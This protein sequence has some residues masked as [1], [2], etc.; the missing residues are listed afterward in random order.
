MADE[1]KPQESP[2]YEFDAPKFFDFTRLLAASENKNSQHTN[3][4]VDAFYGFSSPPQSAT[5]RQETIDQTD[6]KSVDCNGEDI[7]DED[8][9]W[10]DQHN[11]YLVK[12]P[13]DGSLF[14]P[15]KPISI[16]E[17]PEISSTPFGK[18]CIK[19][20]LKKSHEASPTPLTTTCVDNNQ[21][22]HHNSVDD[23][24]VINNRDSTVSTDVFHPALSGSSS[25]LVV[26]GTPEPQPI[27]PQLS[28]SVGRSST[29]KERR[30]SLKSNVLQTQQ[31]IDMTPLASMKSPLRMHTTFNAI[32]DEIAKEQ[33]EDERKQSEPVKV[34]ID[35]SPK[36]VM[37]IDDPVIA[38]PPPKKTVYEA[39]MASGPIIEQPQT[40]EKNF[41]K[42]LSPKNINSASR[43]SPSSPVPDPMPIDSS[44]DEDKEQTNEHIDSHPIAVK[45]P[46]KSPKNSFSITSTDVIGEGA[47]KACSPSRV[48]SLA[49]PRSS[50]KQI[51]ELAEAIEKKLQASHQDTK[52]LP[53]SIEPKPNTISLNPN[54][55]KR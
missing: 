18:L 19:N 48:F 11:K 1:E 5:K 16:L 52:I 25:V 39:I 45:T 24:N 4:S 7:F 36:Q 17:D 13:V 47:G 43:N 15:I 29:K 44:S 23:A 28:S 10:F 35:S 22:E 34:T 14:I 40:P 55:P 27:K 6:N 21:E 53:P 49:P 37:E 20:A 30:K 50:P 8:S 51:L 38:Q 41:K 31:K 2:D 12:S 42:T 46:S 26:K 9:K 3:D 33:Y 32:L 54:I